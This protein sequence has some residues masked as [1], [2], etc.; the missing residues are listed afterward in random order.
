MKYEQPYGV[1]DP[2]GSYTNGNPTTGTMGSIP[3]AAS[4]ENPQREIVNFIT[5][6]SIAPSDGDLYQL[7]RSVQNG[8]VNFA[9][10][11][12]TP[13]QIAITLV[14]ALTA[15]T[16]GLRLFIKV[17]YANTTQVVINVNAL[18]SVP[19][20]HTDFTQLVGS[21]LSPGMVF[22]CIYD[23]GGHFQM[24]SGG[25]G[26]GKI[27]LTA[28]RSVYVNPSTGSDTAYDGSQATVSTSHG[29]FQTITRALQEMT[30]YNLGGWS[31]VINL[32]DGTYAINDTI[33][34]PTPNG[35]GTVL[36]QGNHA[37]PRNVHVANVNAGS[38]FFFASGG[39]WNVDGISF[40]TTAQKPGDLANCIW[41]AASSFV[42]VNAVAFGPCAGSHVCTQNATLCLLTG[43]VEIWGG[44]T[45]AH[46]YASA[47]SSIGNYQVPAPPNL[48][49]TAAANFGSAF[50]AVVA[51]AYVEAIYGSIAGYGNVTGAKYVGAA[52]GIIDVGGRGTSYL[53]GSVA[54]STSTGAQ[55]I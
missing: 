36:L 48:N 37:S 50:V 32:A 45:Y 13:N 53:P 42:A 39:N 2:N 19:L 55:Y 38:C 21:E 31:F 24:L 44:A 34:M 29:P 9:S 47:N 1:S 43:P 20:V 3:P 6:S 23:G 51:G 4:I 52:N 15:Y 8:V 30:K 40:H 12:G 5:S 49:V 27:M 54:G 11:Q 22:E 14:P 18:G 41:L 26:G 10:D 16:A 7:A 28:T 46:Y 17:A 35:S 25:T 33:S